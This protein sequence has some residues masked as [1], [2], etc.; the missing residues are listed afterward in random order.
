MYARPAKEKV[1]IAA[2]V[3]LRASERNTR[4][5]NGRVAALCAASCSALDALDSSRPGDPCDGA[6]CDSYER[7]QVLKEHFSIPLNY[8]LRG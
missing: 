4:A 8:Y 1:V 6:S 5:C 3:I 7:L 2:T